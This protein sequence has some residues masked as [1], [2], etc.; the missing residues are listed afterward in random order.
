VIQR[1][2]R[3]FELV[4]GEGSVEAWTELVAAL[5]KRRA[6]GEEMGAWVGALEPEL[7]RWP[8]DVARLLPMAWTYRLAARGTLPEARLANT[9]LLSDAW[10]MTRFKDFRP[11]TQRPED[12][13][14]I[15]GDEYDGVEADDRLEQERVFAAVELRSIR[16]LDISYISEDNP[17]SPGPMVWLMDAGP[18]LASPCLP[19]LRVLKASCALKSWKDAGKQLCEVL[20]R[21]PHLRVLDISHNELE[22]EDLE[23]LAACPLVARL[24]K[25]VITGNDYSGTGRSALA[26]VVKVVD[27]DAED[28]AFDD[29]ES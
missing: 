23:A 22:A 28:D 11:L 17:Y 3:E 27:L 29:D 18:L 26:K 20:R 8:E 6:A 5:E 15:L 24:E 21:A 1:E 4:R 13:Y 10:A 12:E 19:G 9:L 14:D 7:L 25:L 16:S 2:G